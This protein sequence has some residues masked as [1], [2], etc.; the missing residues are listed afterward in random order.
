MSQSEGKHENRGEG[1]AEVNT[2]LG[3]LADRLGQNMSVPVPDPEGNLKEKQAGIPH[4]GSSAEN[5]KCRPPNQWLDEKQEERT[6]EDDGPNQPDLPR[7]RT[8]GR[9]AG[10][11]S[12]LSRS[13]G[14]SQTTLS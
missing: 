8:I 11:Q 1:Q 12:R 5:G 7:T 2:D 9:S 6:R 3:S 4:L 14:S 10:A 13:P